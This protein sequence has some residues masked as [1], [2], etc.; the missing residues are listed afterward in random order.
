[1][2]SKFFKDKEMRIMISELTDSS[3]EKINKL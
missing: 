2:L 3:F 1:L